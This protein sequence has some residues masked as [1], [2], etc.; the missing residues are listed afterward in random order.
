MLLKSNLYSFPY[1]V[2]FS[3]IITYQLQ[4]WN[5]PSPFLGGIKA[6]MGSCC[7]AVSLTN[8]EIYQTLHFPCLSVEKRDMQNRIQFFLPFLTSSLLSDLISFNTLFFISLVRDVFLDLLFT[9]IFW[10][11]HHVTDLLK[12][13]H[14]AHL[15][16]GAFHLS[17]TAFCPLGFI[18]HCLQSLQ[19]PC[20]LGWLPFS[21]IECVFANV[22]LLGNQDYHLLARLH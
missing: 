5:V 21:L 15:S 22:L 16:N 14:F 19:H 7:H 1:I 8:D 18:C 3:I 9:I 20:Q 11:L 6:Q 13:K 4:G 10:C 17:C 12:A 2:H